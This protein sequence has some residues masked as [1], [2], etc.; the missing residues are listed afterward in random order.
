MGI[1]YSE[2]EIAFGGLLD[3][4]QKEDENVY[5]CE[6]VYPSG[7]EYHLRKE[8][9]VLIKENCIAQKELK[10]NHRF[11]SLSKAVKAVGYFRKQGQRLCAKKKYAIE[12]G[13]KTIKYYY[14]CSA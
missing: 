4:F 3:Y 8:K 5:I 14:L 12:N 6:V 13:Y 9:D 11:K 7:I 2:P 10:Q 1:V